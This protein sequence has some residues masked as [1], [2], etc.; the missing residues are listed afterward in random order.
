MRSAAATNL[1]TSV[2]GTGRRFAPA[3]AALVALCL[4]PSA[5]ALPLASAPVTTG[6]SAGTPELAVPDIS[7]WN[8][9]HPGSTEQAEPA[10][11]TPTPPATRLAAPAEPA[12]VAGPV[13][14]RHDD[15]IVDSGESAEQMQSGAA[16][17]TSRYTPGH[18]RS[19]RQSSGGQRA[20]RPD[21]ETDPA[22]VSAFSAA[23]PPPAH[24]TCRGG[25]SRSDHCFASRLFRPPRVESR[26]S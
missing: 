16:A 7:V 22:V 18:H 15:D 10:A 19:L 24:Y 2:C 14:P 11:A 17:G 25:G 21:G 4:A 6:P 23:P 9:V 5:Y 13:T 12:W 3:A 26:L 8:F 20:A 1:G